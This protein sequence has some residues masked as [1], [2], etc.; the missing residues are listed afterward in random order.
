MLLFTFGVVLVVDFGDILRFLVDGLSIGTVD[1]CSSSCLTILIEFWVGSRSDSEFDSG[2]RGMVVDNVNESV[3]SG[4]MTDGTLKISQLEMMILLRYVD[5]WN[6][7][8]FDVY[9]G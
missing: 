2:D 3:E 4:F 1:D 6:I 8:R 7:E 5:L 9:L